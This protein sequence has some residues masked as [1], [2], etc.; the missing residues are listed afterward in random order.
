MLRRALLVAVVVVAGLQLIPYGWSHPNP[1][2]VQDAPWPSVEA[3]RLAEAACYACH[4]NETDW[5]VYSYVAPMSWLVR[6]DVETG[7]EELNF[8][9]WDRDD[10]EADDAAETIAD[11]SMPPWRYTVA[12]PDARLS[13]EQEQ[14]LIDAL[15]AMED[16]GERDG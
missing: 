6:N 15:L 8:S 9:E 14:V 2:V 10:G 7:R 11:D 3:R 1:P 5:P 16:G 12:H 4:S 13:N